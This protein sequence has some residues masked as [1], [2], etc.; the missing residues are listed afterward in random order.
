MQR[1]E[2]KESEKIGPRTKTKLKTSSLVVI[3]RHPQNQVDCCK[4]NCAK[5]LSSLLPK[6]ICSLEWV[7]HDIG[8]FHN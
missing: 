6:D 1:N 3:W 5:S 7:G 4:D 8:L 2:F